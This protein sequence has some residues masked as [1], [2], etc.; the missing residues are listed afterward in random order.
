MIKPIFPLNE[1]E[2]IKALKSYNILDSE[3]EEIFDGITKLAISICNVPIG[4]ISLIDENRQWFKSR[5]GLSAT[6]TPRDTSFCVHAINQSEIFYIEDATMDDRFKDNP[7]VT[8]D[9]EIIFYAGKPLVNKNGYALGTLCVMDKKPRK[10]SELQLNQLNLLAD[11]AIFLIES[12]INIKKLEETFS[13]LNKLAKNMPGMIYT[14]QLFPDESSC[15]P[16]ASEMIEVL[17]EIK[18]KDV[19]HDSSKFLA[20]IHPDDIEK[21]LRSIKVSAESLTKWNYEYR[22][23]SP[24]AGI[25][26]HSGSANPEKKENEGV[27]W[28]GYI[29]DI[30]ELK[31]QETFIVNSQKMASLGEMASGI[32]HEINNPLA[33]IQANAS[34]LIEQLN[35]GHVPKEDVLSTLNKISETSD[36]IDRIVKGLRSISRN[37]NDDDFEM[38]SVSKL[39]EEIMSLS[40]EKL[41]NA[42]VKMTISKPKE[43]IF[44]ECSHTLILQV[45]I[46][47]INNAFDAIDSLSNKWITV[48]FELINSNKFLKCA[49]TDCGMGIPREVVAK[50]MQPFFTTKEVGKGTGLG[51]SISNGLIHRHNGHFYYNEASKNT[52]FVFEIPL[53]IE[54]KK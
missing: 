27:I 49:V 22:I 47:L 6:E 28:H 4:L 50:L 24:T 20:R 29:S 34:L 35:V 36:R 44:I 53:K 30:T 23:I 10:L 9:P 18:L 52:Q 1:A 17:Y 16:Y 26:W 11:Q 5:Q 48:D 2:R 33:I 31:N 42:T 3:C 12:R 46:N 25:R 51:L 19:L 14:F 38:V 32:G 37:A 7:L 13:F 39:V 41:I 21:V 8:G 15:F 43:D 40:E 45:L 54:L